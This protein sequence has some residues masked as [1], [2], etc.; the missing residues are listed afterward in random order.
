M[1]QLTLTHIQT[2][3]IHSYDLTML[4]FVEIFVCALAITLQVDIVAAHCAHQ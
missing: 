2:A 1:N 4:Q 3:Q